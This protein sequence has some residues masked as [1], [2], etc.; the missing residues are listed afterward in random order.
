MGAAA[1]PPKLEPPQAGLVDAAVVEALQGV[2]AAGVTD[3]LR[4]N[5]RRTQ[6]FSK[7]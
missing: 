7:M 1:L 4:R 5:S 2:E 6:V 3:W